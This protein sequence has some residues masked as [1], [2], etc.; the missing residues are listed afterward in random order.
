MNKWQS[1]VHDS[2]V[3]FFNNKEE[4][5]FLFSLLKPDML[6]LEWGSGSSTKEISSRVKKLYSIEHNYNWYN[7]VLSQINRHTCNLYNIP[8]NKKE[9]PGHD[10]TYND[11]EDYINFP[12]R[13]VKNSGSKF[14]LI[15]VDGRARVECA[16]EAL[17]LLKEGGSILIHDIFNPDHKCDRPEYF[18][19]LNFLHPVAGEYALWQ[20]KPKFNLN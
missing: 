4:E 17:N 2:E 5:K 16:R 12:S 11:Y 3:C 9:R 20:F 6:V 13:I 1:M 14:D 15:L 18:E 19:V 8:R 10:G 7:T